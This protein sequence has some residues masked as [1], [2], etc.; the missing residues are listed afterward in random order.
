VKDLLKSKKFRTMV[1][2]FLTT[3]TI[4]VCA[5]KGIVLD[6]ATADYLA[7]SILGLASAYILAQ[8]AADFG[9]SKQEL[10]AGAVEMAQTVTLGTTTA[11]VSA[12]APT[13][14]EAPAEVEAPAEKPAEEKKEESA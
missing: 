12:D 11:L 3:A 1:L 13:T 14:A 10:L 6:A 2:G 4:K 8:G 7:N 9:K 5:L